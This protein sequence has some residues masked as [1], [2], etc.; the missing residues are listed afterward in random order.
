[1]CNPDTITAELVA[2]YRSG[3]VNRVS[4]GVQSMVDHVLAAL[5]RSHRSEHVHD[6]VALVREGGFDSFNVDLIYGAVGGALDDWRRTADGALGLGPP[7][8]GAYGLTVERG[9]PLADDPSRYPDDD[10][11]AAEYELAD[12]RL[13]AAGLEN[14][15]ISNWAVPGHECRH[16]LLYW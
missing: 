10:R 8:V 14:Y 12:E 2:A 11:Q 4:I 3:G 16:N 6:A 1:E 9:T 15:E 7:H 5:G 13:V